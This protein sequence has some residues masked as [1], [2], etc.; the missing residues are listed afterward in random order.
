MFAG[1]VSAE[2]IF[3]F[4]ARV[5]GEGVG[6]GDVFQVSSTV[7]LNLLAEA[8]SHG[9]IFTFRSILKLINGYWVIFSI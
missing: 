5:N 7:S 2:A 4:G 8:K 6:E 9:G 1:S 3:R